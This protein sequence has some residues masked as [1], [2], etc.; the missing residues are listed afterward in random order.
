[1]QCV[2]FIVLLTVFSLSCKADVVDSIPLQLETSM[3]STQSVSGIAR[4]S[5]TTKIVNVND[6][7]LE[8][9]RDSKDYDYGFDPPPTSS[10][11]AALNRWLK[12]KLSEFFANAIPY[13]V[14]EIILYI[15]A[16]GSIVIVVASIMKTGIF[17]LITGKNPHNVSFAEITEDI[18]GMDFPA[19]IAQSLREGEYR[20]SVRLHYLHVL[21]I[22]TDRGLIIW[23][24]EKTNKEYYRDL[25]PTVLSEPFVGISRI[26]DYV[27]YGERRITEQEYREIEQQ[28]ENC[29]QLAQ[30]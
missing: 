2:I 16:I 13:D 23:K 11:G 28:F 7:V 30:K 27:W 18:H 8:T 24:P 21:K 4:D 26:F 12:Q 25:A 19:L 20:Y 5:A 6:G 29:K 3:V 9:Y 14:W 22:L 15:L 1:M 10:F 17:T